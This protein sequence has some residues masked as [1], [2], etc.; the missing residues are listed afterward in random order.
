MINEI[1]FFCYG[2]SSKSSTWSN[3]PYLFTKTLIDKGIIIHRVDISPNRYVAWLYNKIIYSITKKIGNYC[4][5]RYSKIL[6][7][8]TDHLIKRSV[9]KYPN[10]DYC[11]FT[12][13]DYYNKFS[14]IKTLLF[15]DWTYDVLINERL[16]RKTTKK[17]ERFLVQQKEAI[18]SAEFVV[19]IFPECATHIRQLY[20]NA[21]VKYIDGYVINSF[22][23]GHLDCNDIVHRKKS[24]KTILFIGTK[25]YKKA[26]LK[27]IDA[28]K[29]LSDEDPSLSLDIIGMTDKEF[30]DYRDLNINCY[31]YLKKDVSEECRMYYN[32]LLNSSVIVN[33]DPLWG[34][35]SSIVE[36]MFFYTPV[37]VAPYNDFTKLFGKDIT[38]GEYNEEYSSE[39]IARNISKIIHSEEYNEYCLTAH[40]A[41]KNFTWNAYVDKLLNIIDNDK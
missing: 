37:I 40:N 41:V 8:Y 24:S 17:D 22:Y 10:A 13:F 30:K 29:L 34:G 4:S 39:C 2:D 6:S 26:A 16:G 19:S 27:L 7:I 12:S 15:C 35:I 14:D 25:K 20:P 9:L 33:C 38:F 23:E 5:F 21:N 11:I 3:V 36:A 1:I 32:V 28:L 18:I 31:G